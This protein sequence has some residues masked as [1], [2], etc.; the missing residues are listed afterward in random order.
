LSGIGVGSS[1]SNR[2]YQVGLAA[3]QFDAAGCGEQIARGAL[4]ATQDVPLLGHERVELALQAA[5][6]HSAGV[7]APFHIMSLTFTEIA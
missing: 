4:Y 2:D 6:R 1:T 5:E 3:D 7:R